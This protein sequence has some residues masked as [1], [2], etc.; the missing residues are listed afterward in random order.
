MS[1]FI[2]TAIIFAILCAGPVIFFSLGRKFFGLTKEQAHD[3]IKRSVRNILLL[4]GI[5]IIVPSL[6]FFVSGFIDEVVHGSTPMSQYLRHIGDHSIR[7]A[8]NFYADI[9]SRIPRG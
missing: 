7:A 6:F 2:N 3:H 5:V 1:I 9:I 8:Y 4:F